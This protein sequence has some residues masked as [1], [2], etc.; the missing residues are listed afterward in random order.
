MRRST[1]FLVQDRSLPKA[2]RICEMCVL[3]L[4]DESPVP[5]PI[6]RFLQQQETQPFSYVFHHYHDESK[7]RVQISMFQE[8]IWTKTKIQS[9]VKHRRFTAG[10]IKGKDLLTYVCSSNVTAGIKINANEFPLKIRNGE[11]T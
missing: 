10:T 11:N 4:L 1:Y 7:S 9:N 3:P 5:F 8:S 6:N 2:G